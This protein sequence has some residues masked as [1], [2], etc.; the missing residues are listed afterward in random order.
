MTRTVWFW[1]VVFG[2][3]ILA[4]VVAGRALFQPSGGASQEAPQQEGVQTQVT[5][6]VVK[7]ASASEGSYVFD[8]YS[9]N[10]VPCLVVDG[11]FGVGMD[12]DWDTR[13]FP[14]AP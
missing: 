11:Q 7:L 2:V 1:T 5:L 14:E 4:S 6:V 10:N 13:Y 8:M 9:V 3:L 12:C